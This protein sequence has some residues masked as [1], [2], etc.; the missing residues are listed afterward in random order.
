MNVTIVEFF[1]LRVEGLQ[2][3]P[4]FG[5][6]TLDPLGVLRGVVTDDVCA[7]APC[8]HNATCTNTWNDYTSVPH[9]C[10][11]TMYSTATIIMISV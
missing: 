4:P 5:V 9:P 7:R 3:P 1:P 2:L 6:V 11:G 10:Y 8:H